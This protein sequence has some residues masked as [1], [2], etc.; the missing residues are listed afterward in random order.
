M[1]Y[2]DE[3]RDGAAAAAL[4]GA[5]ARAATRPWTLMEVCGG[6]THAILRFGLDTLLPDRVTLIHGPGC[7]VCVTPV[8]LIDRVIA[9]AARPG[10]ILCSFGDMLRVPGSRQNL[11][12]AKAA[13]GDVR[14]VYSPLDAVRLAARHPD[15]EVVFFAVGF[16]TT[17][18]TTAMA[19]V[20]AR[21][22]G[23][24]NFSLLVAHVLVPPA[25]EAILSAQANRVQGLLAPGHVCAVVGYEGYEPLAARYEVPVVVTGFEP[26]DILAGVLRC[27]EMLEAG[28]VGVEN[29]Y[30]RVVGRDGNTAAQAA[31][32]EVFR[33][34]DR[35]WRGLGPIPRSGLGLTDA[36]AGFD[37]E[38]RFPLTTA[39]VEE[40]A[41]CIAG[42]VLQGARKPPDCPAFGTRCTPDRP[43][44]A[45]MVSSE[46]ACAAYHRYH[47]P[48]LAAA[49]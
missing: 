47:R 35:Q 20:Q 21:R 10:V 6:Q 3:Y 49:R 16:E 42:L 40:P 29:G 30:A 9:L 23:L 18:P 46:G 26:V 43:L 31:V 48:D 7:P 5:I 17:A 14:V 13:G 24:T 36:Y 22:Q 41:E 38:R 37:A 32:R 1:K 44:G 11:L 39:A 2:V 27:V 15:R 34:A 28:R 45:P 25:V 19:A 33:V 4:G 8:E 12:A